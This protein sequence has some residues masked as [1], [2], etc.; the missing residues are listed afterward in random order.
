[1]FGASVF[2]SGGHIVDEDIKLQIGDF[3]FTWDDK[4]AEINERKHNVAFD[5]AAEVFFDENAI[6]E[7]DFTTDE[8]HRRIIRK[9]MFLASPVL[10]VVFVE[11]YVVDNRQIIRL[12]SAREATKKEARRYEHNR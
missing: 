5:M 3:Y 2:V 9:G 6:E 4:K 8:D 10:F 11:R 7:S 12:I 1:M